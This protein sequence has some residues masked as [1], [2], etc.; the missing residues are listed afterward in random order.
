MTAAALLFALLLAGCYWAP[1]GG[2]G[3][4]TLAFG[5]DGQS[6]ALAGTEDTARIYLY[7]EEGAVF[8]FPDGNLFYQAEGIDDEGGS[9]V[10]I[11]G[12]PEGSWNVL[13]SAGNLDDA[14]FTPV[15]YGESGFTPVSAGANNNVTVTAQPLLF[16]WVG[17]VAGEALSGV[18]TFGTDVY[19]SDENTVYKGNDTSV[20]E[21][22]ASLPS[23]AVV[24]S[25]SEGLNV[26][27]AAS[28]ELWVNT[29]QGIVPYNGTSYVTDFHVDNVD[30]TPVFKSGGMYT[31]GSDSYTVFY[32]TEAGFGGTSFD[33]SDDG[34]TPASWVWTTFDDFEETL[35]GEFVYDFFLYNG[36]GYFA[37]QL[38]A[39]RIDIAMVASGSASDD[40]LADVEFFTISKDDV[41]YTVYGMDYLDSDKIILA[42]DGGVFTAALAAAVPITGLDVVD[43]TAGKEYSMVKS[44][45]NG[46]YSAA[47][48][49]TGITLL[50]HDAGGVKSEELLFASGYP[51]AVTDLTWMDDNT[52][53]L[54]AGEGA[55][56]V[57]PGGLV[58]LD[59]SS[60]SLVWE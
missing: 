49:N 58:T 44:S 25:I 31:A 28:S 13:V 24:N 38:G 15:T 17:G 45:S 16:D 26:G 46:M 32:R 29:S 6:R 48:S 8:Q 36:Y 3:S 52:T 7:S 27:D 30:V 56:T 18:V 40:F 21:V 60:G 12:I 1:G 50:R 4:I 47:V 33:W 59:A 39:F 43:V 20:S 54:I 35:T 14:L 2:T 9:V 51:A 23:G 53:L 57:G 5:G 11:E 10:A 55:E 42:T 37:S 34:G 19:A 22:S 41:E